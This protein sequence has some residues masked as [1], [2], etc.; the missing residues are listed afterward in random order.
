M[1]MTGSSIPEH[2]F[3]S[4][5][6]S[7]C[8]S[9]EHM[10]D[11]SENGDGCANGLLRGQD[12]GNLDRDEFIYAGNGLQWNGR[13]TREKVNF[14]RSRSGS[15]PAVSLPSSHSI[16]GYVLAY[17]LVQSISSLQ[18][19]FCLDFSSSISAPHAFL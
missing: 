15:P 16:F 2:P 9:K 13:T 10:K 6:T 18:T 12:G 5:Q 1:P 4:H 7:G 17:S 14:D 8:D 3:A 11:A 19:F